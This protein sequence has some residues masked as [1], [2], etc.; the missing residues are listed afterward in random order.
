MKNKIN[1]LLIL[2]SL[3]LGQNNY[4]MIDDSLDPFNNK[5]D[6]NYNRWDVALAPNYSYIEI[7]PDINLNLFLNSPNSFGLLNRDF[8]NTIAHH[9]S[10][11]D[12][13]EHN[14]YDNDIPLNL[15]SGIYIEFLQAIKNKNLNMALGLL[16]KYPNFINQLEIKNWY[17]EKMPALLKKHIYLGIIEIFKN[18]TPEFIDNF[19]ITINKLEQK[20]NIDIAK[21]IENKDLL[22][23]DFFD[24][25]TKN[26]S[27][28]IMLNFLKDLS[29]EDFNSFILVSYLTFG[30][31]P[32]RN[33][34][35]KLWETIALKSNSLYATQIFLNKININIDL[36]LIFNL[37]T[38]KKCFE[39]EDLNL[40]WEIIKQNP[41]ILKLNGYY[42]Q[43]Y[44]TIFAKAVVTTLF[45]L[46]TK[47]I[48]E[49]T[50]LLYNIKIKRNI[51]IESILRLN[52]EE[53]TKKTLDYCCIILNK[54]K[55]KLDKKTIIVFILLLNGLNINDLLNREGRNI[56]HL[57]LLNNR[58]DLFSFCIMNLDINLNHKDKFN[59]TVLDLA[60]LIN[61]HLFI[62]LINLKK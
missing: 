13:T 30:L 31:D 10:L 1:I 16:K 46:K 42:K 47:D 45:N 49:I 51:S 28:N 54:F 21:I 14:N 56:L 36:K 60:K 8:V 6:Y 20:Y 37:R 57:S 38:L 53:S 58:V 62:N 3:F 43:Q 5:L 22:F 41:D 59:Q 27:L 52:K 26:K 55:D 34:T 11:N 35:H 33:T 2:V 19:I 61:N 17:E 9:Q 18:L 25:E 44:N 50:K 32:I 7:Q 4:C 29:K 48:E 39:E 15:L 23:L 12:F 40:A 24:K